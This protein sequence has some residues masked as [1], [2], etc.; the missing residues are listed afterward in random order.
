MRA[1]GRRFEQPAVPRPLPATL[2]VAEMVEVGGAAGV[3]HRVGE[4]QREVPADDQQR[5]GPFLHEC[6]H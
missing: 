1:C 5:A 2:D 3:V 4:I 6:F